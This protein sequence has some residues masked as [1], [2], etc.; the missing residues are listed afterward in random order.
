MTGP[1]GGDHA[2][3]LLTLGAEAFEGCGSTDPMMEYWRSLNL[4]EQECCVAAL[5]GIAVAQF[6]SQAR[7]HGRPDA[8]AL[9]REYA[10]F[11]QQDEP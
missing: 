5:L 8:A 3:A 4:Y 11:R 2:L 1:N 10:L 7:Q 9:I 6:A